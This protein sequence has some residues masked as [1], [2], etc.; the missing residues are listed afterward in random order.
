MRRGRLVGRE[1]RGR[2]EAPLVD[3]EA[4]AWRVLGERELEVALRLVVEGA[5]PGVSPEWPGFETQKVTTSV[6]KA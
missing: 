1:E 4:A 2:L 6:G 3:G 5:L